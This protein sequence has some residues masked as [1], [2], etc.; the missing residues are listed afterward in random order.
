[1]SGRPGGHGAGAGAPRRP[2]R[3]ARKMKRAAFR[4]WAE[5]SPEHRALRDYA[6]GVKAYLRGSRARVRRLGLRHG[7]FRRTGPAGLARGAGASSGR[8]SH[9]AP[10]ADAGRRMRDPGWMTQHLPGEIVGIDASESMLEI[11]RERVPDG[12]FVVGDAPSLPFGV[13][14]F[15]RLVTGHFYGHLEEPERSQFLGEARRVAR[16]LVVVDSALH[17]G[18][19][20]EEWARA[21]AERWLALGSLSSATSPVKSSRP[22]SAA[23]RS[24]SPGTGSSRCA[25]QLDAAALVLPVARVVTARQ[26]PVPRVRRRRLPDRVAPGV[27]GARR[28]E[29]YILGQAPGVVEGQERR[30]WRGR[31]GQTL[32]RW[33]GLGEEEFYATFYCASVTRC[34]PGRAPGGGDR[35]LTARE[36][37]LCSSWREWELRLLQPRLLVPVGARDPQAARGGEPRR[38]DRR[39]LRTRGRGRAVPLPHP[40]GV[41]RWMNAQEN[42]R[43]SSGCRARPSRAPRPRRLLKIGTTDLLPACDRREELAT[44]G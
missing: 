10:G 29:A 27:R 19:D 9:S 11:A 20:P 41:S 14:S 13:R 43:G 12:R 25:R 31:A 18:V 37:E 28:P 32:R 22:S 35:T 1:M 2:A 33:L 42:R 4:A 5:R 23:A 15:D 16:E 6:C 26:L 24:T 39:A 34:Y 7:P 17:D 38:R 44:H 30:P 3:L 40:S 8:P 36:Q 21:G